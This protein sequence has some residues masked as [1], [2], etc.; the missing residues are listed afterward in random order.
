[1]LGENLNDEFG[2]GFWISDDINPKPKSKEK[3]IDI[4]KISTEITAIVDEEL[5]GSTFITLKNKLYKI[6]QYY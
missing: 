5:E 6:E 3:P 4:S 1:M 2:L